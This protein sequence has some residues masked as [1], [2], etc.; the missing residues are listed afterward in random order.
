MI[1]KVLKVGAGEL[2]NTVL[3]LNIDNF[4]MT[5]Y[6]WDTFIE[7]EIKNNQL[8]KF[9][10]NITDNKTSYVRFSNIMDKQLELN[11]VNIEFDD[12]GKFL[13]KSSYQNHL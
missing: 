7:S 8:I 1:L 10:G 12:F 3:Y 5:I 4:I 6:I 13:S 11:R 2:N 9:K